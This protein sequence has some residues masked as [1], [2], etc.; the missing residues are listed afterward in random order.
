MSTPQHLTVF[1]HVL[2]A[3]IWLGG[4]LALA[5]LA[6]VLRTWETTASGN[7]SSTGSPF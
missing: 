6:P 5:L 4:M 3:L 1:L 2:A 7:A